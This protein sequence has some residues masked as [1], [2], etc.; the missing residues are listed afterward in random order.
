MYQTLALKVSIHCEGCKKKVKRVLQSIEGVYK[1]DIDVQQ[2]KVI[3]TGNVSLD[4][5]VKKLAKT[6]KHAEPWP[7]P[8][9]PPPPPSAAANPGTGKKKK[10][11]NRNK[12]KPADQPPPPPLECGGGPPENQDH[13]GTCD[14]ASDGEQPPNSEAAAAGRGV[15]PV[16]ATV[17]FNGGGGGGGG[18][19]KKKGRG[20]GGGGNGDGGGGAV[21]EASPPTRRAPEPR[22]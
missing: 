13:A 20:S 3:V 15:H 21:A 2:H 5:L 7:E 12:N 17:N 16:P 6:G 10:K 9:A 8:A 14:E 1:T 4:A 22:R 11:K 19:K 18:K